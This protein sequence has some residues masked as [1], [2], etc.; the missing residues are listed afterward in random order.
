[1]RRFR[2]ILSTSLV[3]AWLVMTS[4][5]AEDAYDLWLRYAPLEQDERQRVAARVTAIVAPGDISPTRQAALDEL[6]RAFEGFLGAPPPSANDIRDGALVV[7]TPDQSLRIASLNLPL[8][9]LGEIGR[10]HV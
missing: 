4:A 10:A 7:A 6:A 1:M 2:K 8:E 9:S 5:G 3:L